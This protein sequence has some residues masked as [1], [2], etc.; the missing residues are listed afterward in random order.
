MKKS[1]SVKKGSSLVMVLVMLSILSV[2]GAAILSV[3]LSSYKVRR[4][5]EVMKTNFYASEAGLDKAYAIIGK[6]VDTAIDKGNTAVKNEEVNLSNI[7]HEE[8]LKVLAD[9]NYSSPYLNEDGSVNEEKIKEFQ[10]EKFQIAFRDYIESNLETE[11]IKSDNYEFDENGVGEKFNSDSSKP[12]MSFLP[13]TTIP[14][15]FSD[16]KMEIGLVSTFNHENLRKQVEAGYEIVVPEYKAV[17][18]IE[19][20]I[21]KVPENL[22]F[23]KGIAVDGD[24]KVEGSN[25]D[26]EGDVFVKG[27][28]VGENGEITNEK[29]VKS[30]IILDKHNSNLTVN[31]ELSSAQNIF[32]KGTNSNLVVNGDAYVRNAIIDTS[33]EGS[34]LNINKDDNLSGSLFTMDDLELNAKASKINIA[35]GFYGVSDGSA[36]DKSNHSSSIIVN[37]ED[38]GS[39]SSIN[40][41]TSGVDDKVLIA[42][43]SYIQL[44]NNEEYQ[45]GESV[46]I[47]G[48]Y[49]A[50]TMPLTKGDPKNDKE[51]SLKENNVTF[52]YK[53]PLILAS[54]FLDGIDLNVFDKSYYFKHYHNEYKKDDDYKLNLGGKNGIIIKDKNKILANTGAIICSNHD[55]IIESNFGNWDEVRDKVHEIKRKIFYMGENVTDEK[56]LETINNVQQKVKDKV[57]FSRITNKFVGKNTEGKIDNSSDVILLNNDTNKSY[58]FAA[59]G[60]NTSSISGE[61]V[62]VEKQGNTAEFRGIIITAGDV[63][64]SGNINF[65]GTIICGGSLIFKDSNPKEITYDGE[66]V[67]RLIGYNYEDF[68]NVFQ[69]NL[70]DKFEVEAKTSVGTDDDSVKSDIIRDKLITR[71]KWKILK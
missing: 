9:K 18:Y 40:I 28:N 61:K 67:K 45:T 36:S 26:I 70:S 50:Y 33:A 11:L 55:E 32:L 59:E 58:V 51:K 47:K 43:S 69:N 12:E 22:A 49:K 16:D 6:I 2:F 41:E 65:K 62:T 48:N 63:Y 7:I 25:V 21:I 13:N 44:Y 17:Y 42:G 37:A 35:G 60:V 8:K 54:K 4:M 64:F 15:K 23:Q 71:T 53:E 29:E 68:K 14:L 38:I 20:S 19:N 5:N 30:G 34:N 10:N 24:M 27:T 1:F 46:S 39:G 66:Y 56:H 3:T 57:N 31:G 52:E